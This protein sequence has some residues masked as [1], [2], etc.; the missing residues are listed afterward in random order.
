LRTEKFC[1]KTYKS[2]FPNR[3]GEKK[4]YKSEYRK[5]KKISNKLGNIFLETVVHPDFGDDVGSII[6]LDDMYYKIIYKAGKRGKIH[7]ELYVYRLYD[8]ILIIRGKG[9]RFYDEIEDEESD[10]IYAQDL[11]EFW[12]SLRNFEDDLR[13]RLEIAY[14]LFQNDMN[15]GCKKIV[16]EVLHN[17]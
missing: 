3:N 8:F 9:C 17:L 12:A 7:I 10:I 13:M 1:R 16:E 2:A 5:I 6:P 4:M 14:N 11:R 15:N